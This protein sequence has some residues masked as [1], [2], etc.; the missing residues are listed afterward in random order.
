MVKPISLP[1]A[2]A[3]YL[4]A[5]K[6]LPDPET[7]LDTFLD[8][9]NRQISQL[10]CAAWKMGALPKRTALVQCLT[11]RPFKRWVDFR[12]PFILNN[13][14]PPLGNERMHLLASFAH[15]TWH[16]DH[17]EASS[18]A[19]M[20]ID[21]DPSRGAI[22]IFTKEMPK[23]K[24]SSAPWHTLHF[25]FPDAKWA[26]PLDYS[27][28]KEDLASADF[29]PNSE[30]GEYA[31]SFTAFDVIRFIQQAR[32]KCR[33]S[34]V[35]DITAPGDWKGFA[36]AAVGAELPDKIEALRTKIIGDSA[37]RDRVAVLLHCGTI[38]LCTPQ[39]FR[40]SATAKDLT[41][42][43]IFDSGLTVIFSDDRPPQFSELVQIYAV[44]HGIGLF[45]ASINGL[46]K[47]LAIQAGRAEAHKV[48][49]IISHSLDGTFNRSESDSDLRRA[50]LL[51][52]I[53]LK[54]GKT[55]FAPT[56]DT[57]SP[58][59][60][61]RASIGLGESLSDLI[62]KAVFKGNP[63]LALSCDV[64]KN[65]SVH[66]CLASLVIELSENLW[67]HSKQGGIL[68]TRE[69]DDSDRL[70]IS[71]TGP[72]NRSDLVKVSEIVDGYSAVGRRQELVGLDFIFL[73][74]HHIGIEHTAQV[75]FIFANPID[76]AIA[77]QF[78]GKWGKRSFVFDPV[79]RPLPGGEHFKLTI[80]FHG[81]DGL[82]H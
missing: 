12:H 18:H 21:G 77:A 2:S 65:Q 10:I 23:R 40:L 26:K 48:F 70:A 68:V 31:N 33:Q 50:V 22:V 16:L 54:A 39:A 17:R 4:F 51:E 60:W 80:E 74:A 36:T 58:I 41:D 75:R 73:L 6:A 34:I 37:Y 78:D 14:A 3:E 57:S 7:D 55:L 42:E 45:V 62:S 61:D 67:E 24:W 43:V 76:N 59:E 69:P 38:V 56:G 81:L 29:F 52:A 47:Y 8:H 13:E 64:L 30:L 19:R 5:P 27:D 49:G 15:T 11:K 66:R 28:C 1:F 20:R 79:P 53:N 25:G 82:I 63:H 9:C 71:L 46:A 35:T 32:S 44:A 72:A